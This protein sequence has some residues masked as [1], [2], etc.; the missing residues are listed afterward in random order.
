MTAPP[1]FT[2]AQKVRFKHCDPAGIVFYP[3]YFEMINDTV[4]DFFDAVVG[5]PFDTMMPETGVPTA[6]IST[7]FHAPS[8]HGDHLT[9][10]V[11]LTRVGRTSLTLAQTGTCG[12]EARFDSVLTVVHVG[13]DGRPTPWPAQAA[14][15][16]SDY[17]EG[18]TS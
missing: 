1:L 17:H 14:Q 6:S 13:P 7:Q 12:D 4:E 9:I 16:L 10:A 8:R 3:R 11:T 15:T 2:R 5:Y 18:H